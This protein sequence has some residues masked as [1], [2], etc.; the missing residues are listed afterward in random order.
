MC[1]HSQCIHDFFVPYSFPLNYTLPPPPPL[2][3]DPL[4]AN[5]D[6][7]IVFFLQRN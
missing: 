5:I 6:D 4:S 1:S 2:L 3:P 7:K